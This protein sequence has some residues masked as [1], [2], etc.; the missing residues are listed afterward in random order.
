M[1]KYD[2]SVLIPARNEMFLAKTV[3]D[4]LK[5]KR[6]N[7]EVIVGLDGEWANPGVPVHDDVSVLYVPESLGQRGITNQLCRLSKA[8][9]VMKLDAHCSVDEGFDLKMIEVMRDNYT[10]IPLMRNLHAFD[11]YCAK[12]N[13]RDYQGPSQKFEIC[14][15]CK[16]KRVKDIV[17]RAKDSPRST[18]FRFDKTLHFQYWNDFKKRLSC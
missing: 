4:I 17:W 9:Y 11:W 18:S 16:E 8:K 2:L 15:K 10:L 12:C 6:G 3:E 14:P 7:T 5:N 13:T 1:N